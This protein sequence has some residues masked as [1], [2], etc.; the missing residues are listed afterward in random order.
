M[1]FSSKILIF[2]QKKQYNPFAEADTYSQLKVFF[3]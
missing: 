3:H 2:N 1:R